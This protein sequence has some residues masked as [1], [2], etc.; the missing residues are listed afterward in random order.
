MSSLPLMCVYA[1]VS[2]LLQAAAIGVVFLLE[3]MIGGWTGSAFMALFLLVFWLAWAISV[4]LTAPRSS[5][6]PQATHA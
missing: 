1:V 3:P 2:V 5:S 4:R 6:A